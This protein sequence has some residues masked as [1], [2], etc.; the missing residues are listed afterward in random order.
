[1]EQSDHKTREMLEHGYSKV[2][3]SYALEGL[4]LIPRD[5]FAADCLVRGQTLVDYSS[6]SAFFGGVW[7]ILLFNH[8]CCD[9]PKLYSHSEGS[10]TLFS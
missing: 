1:M 5:N 3:V 2:D 10:N 4:A 9:V 8:F 6:H 7:C